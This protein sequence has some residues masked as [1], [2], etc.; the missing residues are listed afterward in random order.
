[1]TPSTKR[2]LSMLA[3]VLPGATAAATDFLVNNAS[4]IN[5]ALNSAGPGDAIVL[6]DG[7]WTNQAI[8]FDG[9]GA[10]GNP[11]VLRAQTPG[12]V[13]LNGTSRLEIGGQHL[14]VEGLRFEGGALSSGHVIQFRCGSTNATDSVLRDCTIVG[15]NPPD[16]STRYFWVSFSAVIHETSGLP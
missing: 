3:A 11:L 8:E 15:Y 13:I 12:G 7:V 9:D 10:P 14:V 16:R 5:T 6:A 4:E 2:F 1:M